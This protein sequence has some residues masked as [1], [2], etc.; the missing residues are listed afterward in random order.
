MRVMPKVQVW[1]FE[2]TRCSHQWLPRNIDEPPAVCP[3]CKSPDWD[4]P[5][6]SD[7]KAAKRPQRKQKAS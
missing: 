5:R 4:R 7:T 2:C 3:K 6:Q 1:G